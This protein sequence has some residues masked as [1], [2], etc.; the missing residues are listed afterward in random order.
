MDSLGVIDVGAGHVRADGVAVRLARCSTTIDLGGD[1]A[2]YVQ[3]PAQ[4]YFLLSVGGYH[5]SFH[6]PSTVPASMHDLRRMRGLDRRSPP[7]SRSR[8]EAYFAVT[9]NSLQFGA[10]VNLEASV[11]FWPTTYTAT[12]LV[13]RSTCCSIFSPFQ[14]VAA[15]PPAS[16]STPAT[17]S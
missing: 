5:P 6:P 3:R 1:M 13:R 14:I 2:M 12:R 11:E 17:R 16:A 4:P 9:S 8:V 7:T 15:C 10:S